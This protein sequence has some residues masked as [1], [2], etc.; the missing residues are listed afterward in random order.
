MLKK[1]SSE[2]YLKN[3]EKAKSF[4][5]GIKNTYEKSTFEASSE[6]SFDEL[7]K[8]SKKVKHD[9]NAVIFY[10]VGLGLFYETLRK[11]LKED[12]ARRLVLLEDSE[13]SLNNFLRSSLASEILAN[14]QVNI[15]FSDD[16]DFLLKKFAWENVLLKVEI[17]AHP[18]YLKERAER[19]LALKDKITSFL[20]G[21]NLIVGDYSDFGEIH[22]RN[23]FKNLLATSELFLVKDFK[24]KFKGIPA[25]VCGAGPSVLKN[26]AFI[27]RLK[28][29]ALIISGGA[30]LN[31]L[32]NHN[33]KPHFAVNIDKIAP[34]ERF[35]KTK[36][37]D[38]PYFVQMQ[39]SYENYLTI[40]SKK[41]L[42][43]PND[44]YPLENFV[45]QNLKIDQEGFEIGWSV[46]SA[47]VSVAAFL[48][49]SPII[50]TGLDFCF[51]KSKY[52]ENVSLGKA[53]ELVETTDVFGNR[54]FTQ[55][56]FVLSKQ[57]L[58]VFA[59]EKKESLL[60]NANEGGLEIKDISR[61]SFNDLLNENMFKTD[62]YGKDKI[63]TFINSLN[64]VSIK[65]ESVKEVISQIRGS[66]ERSLALCDKMILNIDELCRSSNFSF[67]EFEGEIFY[68]AH[69][70][71]LWNIFSFVISRDVVN[72]KKIVDKDIAIFMNKI[73][74]CKNVS[75]KYIALL[76][77]I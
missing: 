68:S 14:P 64:P 19:F 54:V 27:D 32:S 62:I 41:I 21:A 2:E 43:P 75:E 60:I 36:H 12:R 39:L 47:M 63:E 5:S 25:I 74:F 56:D 37:L 59:K 31:I 58:E 71:V 52:P 34:R 77:S 6:A 8:T 4:F 20:Y 44:S 33:I 69:L 65:E 16:E 18:N 67:K 70:L 40:S 28:D 35:E 76:N 48:G 3:L 57:W 11:W 24:G 29:K 17:L 13:E 9:T 51:E 22:F 1:C 45:Y 42:L 50:F 23:T 30:G 10:G 73:I 72:Q 53:V 55:K 38:M 49:C 46:G 7:K 15:L 26:I 61:K 66:V